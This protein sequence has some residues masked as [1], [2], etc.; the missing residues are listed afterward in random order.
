MAGVDAVENE[1]GTVEE[2]EFY[3]DGLRLAASVHR[4]AGWSAEHGHPGIV[5]CNG[6]GASKELVVPDIADALAAVGFVALRFDYR[7]FGNS[8]GHPYRLIPHE[9]VEDARNAVTFLASLDGVDPEALGVYGTSF[10]GAHAISLAGTDT[11]VNAVVA[12]VPVG[13]GPRWMQSLRR[14][15][16][17]N[18]FQ[19]RVEADRITRVR[20]GKSTWVSSDEVM[21]PDPHSDS[22]HQAIIRQFPERQYNL[23]LETADAI[24]SY[25]PYAVAHSIAPRPV[26]VIAVADDDLVPT[27]QAEEIYN[28]CGEPKRLI[29][30]PGI[31]HHDVYTGDPFQRVLSEASKWFQE[32]L[33]PRVGW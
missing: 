4:P 33:A 1:H 31:H 23:P 20:T 24:L 8:E 25:R 11:R 9:Q 5:I 7:G 3:S 13:N 19:R 18:E 14:N 29:L 17:W 21:V 16:E 6:F 2:T 22:W 26:L 28:S 15:W 32:H 12:V 30:L 27:E 10:G